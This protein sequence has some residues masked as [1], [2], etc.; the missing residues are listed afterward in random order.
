M[1]RYIIREVIPWEGYN[2]WTVFALSSDHAKTLVGLLGP[3]YS[4]EGLSV[5]S[6]RSAKGRKYE[7]IHKYTTKY[8]NY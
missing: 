5:Q 3:N 7:G 4:G 6:E 8:Y 1:K 2:E